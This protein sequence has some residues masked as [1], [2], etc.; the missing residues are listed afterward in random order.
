LNARYICDDVMR[1][2]V[3]R[4]ASPQDVII[5]DGADREECAMRALR[6]LAPGGMIIL[7]NSEIETH[8]RAVLER[9]DLLRVDF[10][11]WT[12]IVGNVQCTSVFFDQ[13]AKRAASRQS[14]R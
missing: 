13:R 5:I 12:T 6:F 10:W 3:E 11:G 14:R 8:A 1:H 4:L 7:D 2:Y 9:S